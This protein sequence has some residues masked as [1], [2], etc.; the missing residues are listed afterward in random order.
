MYYLALGHWLVPLIFCLKVIIYY[1][2]CVDQFWLVSHSG[3]VRT[4]PLH[5]LILFLLCSNSKQIPYV[6][7]RVATQKC[8]H[9]T[10]WQNSSNVFQCKFIDDFI[11]QFSSL[12]LNSHWASIIHCLC[13]PQIIVIKCRIKQGVNRSTESFFSDRSLPRLSESKCYNY[14]N[15]KLLFLFYTDHLSASK[16][17]SKLPC[18][19]NRKM[20]L[21]FSRKH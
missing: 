4:W 13:S 6:F 14:L 1:F 21:M 17:T 15:A 16:N 10:E 12:H 8:V 2:S 9:P 19:T 11:I 18:L 20:N 5:I 7:E 3:V